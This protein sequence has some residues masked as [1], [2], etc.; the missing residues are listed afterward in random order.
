[1]ECEKEVYYGTTWFVLGREHGEVLNIFF[2]SLKRFVLLLE[3]WG[4]RSFFGTDYF[5]CFFD[6][7]EKEKAE[8][9]TK[10]Q[11]EENKEEE[12]KK[13][14]EKKEEEKKKKVLTAKEVLEKELRF[15]AALIR[16]HPKSYWLW[17]HRLFPLFFSPLP[18]FS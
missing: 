17:F 18:L 6:C 7:L 8:E 5:F 2:K 9:Q 3:G 14:E 4:G 1:M 10:E 15:T 16:T 12:D 13:D 11:E